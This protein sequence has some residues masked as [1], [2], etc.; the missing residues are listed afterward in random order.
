VGPDLLDGALSTF[1]ISR[2]GTAARFIDLL[3]HIHTE[4]GFNAARL[5]RETL[6]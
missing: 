3:T 2:F 5:A 1:F 6:Q 4:T